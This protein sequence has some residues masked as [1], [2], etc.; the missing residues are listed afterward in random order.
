ML[1]VVVGFHRR[2]KPG[3]SLAQ[4]RFLGTWKSGNLEIREFEIP[5]IPKM[6]IL[7]IKFRSAQNVGKVWISRKKIILAP[8]GA[9]SVV[10]FSMDRKMQTHKMN[11]ETKVE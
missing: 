2:A 1:M 8:F 11:N 7:K 9:I 10:F 5:Q 4:A 6:E 3:P